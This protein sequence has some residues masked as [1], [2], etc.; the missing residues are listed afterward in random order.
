MHRT[1][2]MIEDWQYERLRAQAE[3][4]GRSISELVREAVSAFLESEP[5]GEPK[6]LTLQ[7]IDGIGDDPDAHGADHD[8]FLYGGK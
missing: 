6:R 8:V 2:L 1:Q 5:P 7:D 4:Q 3:R